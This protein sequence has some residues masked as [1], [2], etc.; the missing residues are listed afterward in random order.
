MEEKQ[1]WLTI[2][3]IVLV[4]AGLGFFLYRQSQQAIDEAPIADEETVT[5]ERAD[6]FLEDMNIELPEDATR[7]NLRDVSDSDGTGI[8]TRRPDGD[9]LLQSVLVALPDPAPGEFYEAYLVS[10]EDEEVEPLRLGRLQMIKGGWALDY[11]LSQ[12]QA[13][14]YDRIQVTL[15]QVDDRAPETVILEADFPREEDSE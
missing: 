7:V 5:R 13:E 9:V 1:N 11:R 4:V 2:G 8:A 15:E 3:A 10:S 12:D 14:T 6:R